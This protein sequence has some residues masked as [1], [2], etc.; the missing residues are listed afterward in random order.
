EENGLLAYK[1]K[2]SVKGAI[3]NVVEF[4]KKVFTPETAEDKDHYQAAT[5][6]V[7]LIQEKVEHA[8]RNTQIVSVDDRKEVL[9]NILI[10]NGITKQKAA[11]IADECVTAGILTF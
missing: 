9:L 6:A 5:Q 1:T 7:F 8:L 3:K 4:H 10:L 2:Q 11:T